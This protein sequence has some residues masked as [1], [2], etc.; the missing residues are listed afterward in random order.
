MTRIVRDKVPT[1]REE[2]IKFVTWLRK[3]GYKCT[4]SANGGSRNLLEAINLKRMGVSAGFPDVEVPFPSGPYHGFYVEMKRQKG[5][6]ISPEQA[7]WLSY[8][9]EKGY[10]AEE[11]KGFEVAKAMFIHYLSFT[12]KAA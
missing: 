9:R 3:E 4:A 7:E 12:P 8:L 6:K 11:A 1:E 2:Q 5:G 10:Y